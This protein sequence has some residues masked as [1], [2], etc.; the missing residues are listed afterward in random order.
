MGPGVD[1]PQDGVEAMLINASIFN[2]FLKVFFL[3]GGW[4]GEGAV[5][6]SK[7]IVRDKTANIL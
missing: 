3:L 1:R 6:H 2:L 5:Y 4:G 7:V